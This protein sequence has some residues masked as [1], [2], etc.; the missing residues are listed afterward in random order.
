MHIITKAP[1][2]RQQ[3]KTPVA[4]N[5][6]GNDRFD[7]IEPVEAWMIRDNHKFTVILE[8]ISIGG[9]GASL[10]ESGVKLKRGDEA[11]LSIP[12]FHLDFECRTAWLS[13]GHVGLEFIYRQPFMESVKEVLTG[14][15]HSQAI[16]NSGISYVKGN[17]TESIHD[18]FMS[19]AS[20]ATVVDLSRVDFMN[21]SGISMALTANARYGTIYAGCR[22]KWH[23]LLRAVGLCRLCKNC[24]SAN[25]K[26]IPRPIKARSA[27]GAPKGPKVI[28]LS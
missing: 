3:A 8:N 14:T 6:R 21:T 7:L 2:A 16:S 28:K 22:Q 17:L 11:K 26:G 23:V 12:H 9:I 1:V 20:T 10:G 27:P 5:K 18:D 15:K 19:V 13:P 24:E 4:E 25:H